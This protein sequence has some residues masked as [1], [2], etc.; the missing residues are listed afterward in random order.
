MRLVKLLLLVASVTFSLPGFSA[1]FQEG[2]DAY[3]RGDYQA[4]L[5][6][7]RPLAE[8]G[9]ARAQVNLGYMYEKGLGVAQRRGIFKANET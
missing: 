4:A 8:Q 3:N 6:E 2:L 9:D 1:D 7:M 5:R